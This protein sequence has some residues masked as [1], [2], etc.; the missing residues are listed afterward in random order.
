MCLPLSAYVW[1]SE[2]LSKPQRSK[3]RSCSHLPWK[4]WTFYATSGRITQGFPSRWS[5]YGFS[6]TGPSLNKFLEL[7]GRRLLLRLVSWKLHIGVSFYPLPCSFSPHIPDLI[8]D[9]SLT[10]LL[11]S[12]ERWF[13][14]SSMRENLL[15]GLS[16]LIARPRVFDLVS[17]GWGPRIWI[18]HKFLVLLLWGLIL[19]ITSPELPCAIKP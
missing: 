10:F 19:S 13:S 7:M 3:K 18:S 5:N 14:S 12:L 6:G 8:P 9:P 16:M 11:F 15:E 17:L 1:S 2:E 4:P